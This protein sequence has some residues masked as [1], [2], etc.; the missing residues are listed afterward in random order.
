[1]DV[2]RLLAGIVLALTIADN[3]FN[4]DIT[5][6][7]RGKVVDEESQ[8]PLP[9]TTIVVLTLDPVMGTTSDENGYFRLD[10]VPVGRHNI[11]VSFMG[12]ES[13]VIPELLVTSGKEI[14]LD[15]GLIEKVEMMDEVVVKAY[16][17]KDKPL[18][19]LSTVSARTFSV[20]EAQRYAGGLDD[21]ARLASSFAGVATG[22]LDDNA[23]IVRGNAPKGLLWRL[24][25]IEIPNPNHFANMMTFG[26]GG[27]SALSSL[28]LA[29]SD[30]FTGAFPA[31]Y[32]NA[33]SGVFDIKLRTGNNEKHEHAV[34][35]GALG[36]DLSSE[37]PFSKN[38][39]ASY[40]FNYRYST[41]GLIKPILP[42]DANIPVYQDLCFKIKLP[43]DKAGIFSLWAL[44][45]DDKIKFEPDADTSVWSYAHDQEVG[46]V[47]Q[48]MAAI[49][50]N[51]RYILGNKTYL[52]SSLALSGDYTE[53]VEDYLDF[54]LTPQASLY[55]NNLNMKY[56][57]T[58]TLNQYVHNIICIIPC[59]SFNSITPPHI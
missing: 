45:A 5:Q 43:T 52:N 39:K 42:E 33:M 47:T 1:M 24:E 9:F 31:E 11:Q 19:S 2:K 57:L 38:N 49:G 34:Q 18:N 29:N 23:I 13:K 41:L 37:G 59:T 8:M 21:P 20:E 12:Y 54:D 15:I 27:I 40:L 17:Q 58:S 51:H 3:A 26:G 53:S 44:A 46:Y 32:G 14:V 50:L 28:M 6:V 56:T 10:K 4:Q 35:L 55:I 48:R 36:L 7:V 16:T 30:F 25:G 22:Y